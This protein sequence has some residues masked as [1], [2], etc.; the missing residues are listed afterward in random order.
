MK[1]ITILLL[2]IFT[3][4][5]KEKKTECDYIKNYY[6]KVYKADLEYQMENYQKAFE[7]YQDAFN[8]CS[9]LNTPLYYEIRKFAKTSAILGKNEIAIEFIKKDINNGYEIESF[10]NDSVFS[11]IFSSKKGQELIKNYDNLRNQY[12]A[13]IDLVF[14]KEMILMHTLDQKYRINYDQVK[15]DSID[16]INET[17]LINIFEK[18]GY[19][20]SN[21]IGNYSIDNQRIDMSI[22]LRHTEDSIRKNYFI[23]KLIEFVKN[24]TCPPMDLAVVEDWYYL[25]RGEK[26]IYGMFPIKDDNTIMDLN[27]VDKNRVSIGLP[28]LKQ[29][30]KKDS[31]FSANQNN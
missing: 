13:K 21:L 31:L 20:N 15:M 12:L 11:K 9:P 3:S 7:Y 24:G 14:R 19:P 23:P 10:T 16:N 28:T 6:P 29:K 27:Q 2:L 25:K 22:I 8:N 4:C 26:Q 1:Y 17:K 18:R 5:H 30:R